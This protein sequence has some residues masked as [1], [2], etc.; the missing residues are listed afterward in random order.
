MTNLKNEKITELMDI[1]QELLFQA[2][3][4]KPTHLPFSGKNG[5]PNEVRDHD[6]WSDEPSLTDQSDLQSSDINYIMKQYEKTGMLP[7]NEKIQGIYQDNTDLPS[8]ETAFNMV[9]SAQ[10][11]FES[12]PADV[13]K[14]MDNDPSQLENFIA[15][16]NN[17]DYLVKKGLLVENYLEPKDPPKSPSA[18]QTTE[19]KEK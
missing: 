3:T 4:E 1:N 19:I 10:D 2:E 12:L 8:L 7:I 9:K 17:R 6:Y 14:L 16:P 5:K 13:R 11:A 18:M 15:D